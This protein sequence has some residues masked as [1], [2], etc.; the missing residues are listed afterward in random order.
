MPIDE[1]PVPSCLAARVDGCRDK[2]PDIYSQQGGS[3]VLSDSGRKDKL[4]A[5]L[6]RLASWGHTIEGTV[7]YSARVRDKKG[8]LWNVY[9]APTGHIKRTKLREN[10]NSGFVGKILKWVVGIAG[11][12]GIVS[13]VGICVTILSTDELDTLDMAVERQDL[14]RQ[15]TDLLPEMIGPSIGGST[16]APIQPDV[17]SPDDLTTPLSDGDVA[18][19]VDGALPG[20]I[21]VITPTSSGSGFIISEDGGAVTNRHVV[22]GNEIVTVLL[23]S[24]HRAFAEVTYTHPTLDL[25][26]IDID[27][28]VGFAPM[29]LGN[30]DAVR[31]GEQ[32]IAIGYPL[33]SL[34]G[35]TPSVSVGIISA[36][37]DDYLQTDAAL[38]PGNSG[39]P[40]LSAKGEV[41][42]VVTS[43]AEWTTAGRPVSGISF[44]IPINE[45]AA[46]SGSSPQPVEP[47]ILAPD[48]PQP[49]STAEPDP[50][51]APP[52]TWVT[53]SQDDPVTGTT[54]LLLR[55]QAAEHDIPIGAVPELVIHCAD[56]DDE[57]GVYGPYH[58]ILWGFEIPGYGSRNFV[59]SIVRWDSE[60][61]ME[62]EDWQAVKGG[63]VRFGSS[64]T[65]FVEAVAHDSVYIRIGAYAGTGERFYARFDLDGLAETLTAKELALCGMPE[66]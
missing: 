13:V 2:W 25:A 58:G 17:L 4:A 31:L 1:G 21:Q 39:G 62:E 26:H 32:V 60:P 65:F 16:P 5:E 35:R 9:V 55:R 6:D 40:L 48:I 14:P 41:V 30:S 18:D 33:G 15:N 42:G 34:L 56:A 57:P 24:G 44:A 54:S 23:N 51:P 11:V 29:P 49:P 19:M 53:A 20:V 22:K 36:K 37:R 59:E 28:H 64:H 43:R 50:T 3:L 27:G 47:T 52:P 38:N 66:E 10:S 8:K 61:A 7:G 46:P 63:T 45:V 12:F